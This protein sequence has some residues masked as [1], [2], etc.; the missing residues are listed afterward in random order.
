MIQSSLLSL[1][2][3]SRTFSHLE[4]NILAQIF[5]LPSVSLAILT[6]LIFYWNISVNFP[7]FTKL[8]VD[9]LIGILTFVNV[10]GTTETFMVSDRPIQSPPHHLLSQILLVLLH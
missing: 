2:R 4:E 5:F 1:R 8:L 10:N 7:R 6:Y 9:I 3:A